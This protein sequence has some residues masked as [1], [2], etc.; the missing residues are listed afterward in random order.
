MVMFCLFGPNQFCMEVT[1]KE[2]AKIPKQI[3]TKSNF[4]RLGIGINEK[5]YIWQMSNDI[6]STEEDLKVK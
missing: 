6:R 5:I 1:E 2:R 3:H 4:T